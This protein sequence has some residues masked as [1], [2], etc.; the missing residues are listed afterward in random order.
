MAAA[1]SG[2][3]AEKFVHDK[4]SGVIIAAQPDATVGSGTMILG[5]QVWSID[6]QGNPV[7]A[8]S[9]D[10]RYPVVITNMNYA[11][12]E[13]YVTTTM[14]VKANTS[15]LKTYQR[16]WP[17]TEAERQAAKDPGLK[18]LENQFVIYYSALGFVEKPGFEEIV[19]LLNTWEDKLKAS[20]MGILGLS[21]DAAAKR[22]NMLWWDDCV[23]HPEVVSRPMGA[24]PKFGARHDD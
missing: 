21:I 5:A 20:E 3:A 1:S 2:Y 23:Y 12:H 10:L 18:Q 11:T 7:L 22:Y 6:D 13:S 19:A 4:F 15:D 24:S 9:D 17:I 8:T 14:V 16:L